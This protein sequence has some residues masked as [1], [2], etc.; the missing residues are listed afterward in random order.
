MQEPLKVNF[1]LLHKGI[2]RKSQSCSYWR[3]INRKN[4]H[5]LQLSKKANPKKP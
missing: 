5:Y 2:K 4:F 3:T 1:N